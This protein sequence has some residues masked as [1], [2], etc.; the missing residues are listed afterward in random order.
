VLHV[1]LDLSR[2]RVDDL[3]SGG[4]GRSFPGAG[5]PRRPVRARA[6]CRRL[7]RAGARGGRVD[8]RRAVRPR[9]AGRARVGGV[10]RRRAA[11]QGAGAVGVQDRQDRRKGAG[12]AL[13]PGPGAG[14]L[15]ADPRAAP[16]AGD[17]AVAA[18]P[19]QASRDPEEPCSLD[20]DRVRAPGPDG[21]PV[22]SRRPPVATRA[23]YSR[24]VARSRRRER[25][26]DRRSPS[27][28]SPRS[29]PSCGAPAA[30][31]ATCRR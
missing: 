22:R 19:G 9:R 1:G 6:P 5:G 20:A 4:A 24:A 10:D 31:T 13:L 25:G 14:D 30:T 8:E 26:A 16:R 15:A 21:R 23:R 3:R 17:L 11:G 18:A 12:G 28:G 29:R 2:K 7:W 27:S